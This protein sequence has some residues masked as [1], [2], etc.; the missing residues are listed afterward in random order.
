MGIIDPVVLKNFN[1]V[2]PISY[3]EINIEDII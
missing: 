3:L 1:I 2:Y